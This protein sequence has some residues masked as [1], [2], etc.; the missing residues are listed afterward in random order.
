MGNSPAIYERWRE[1]AK[2]PR[3]SAGELLAYIRANVEQSDGRWP[4]ADTVQALC[5][6]FT[7][8][9]YEIGE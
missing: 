6:W 5:D 2:Q 9:G 8:H 3:D 4:G 1:S 7:S